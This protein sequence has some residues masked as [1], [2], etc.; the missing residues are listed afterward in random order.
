[1]K[2]KGVATLGEA[3]FSNAG[4]LQIF[5]AMKG[6]APIGEQVD[7]SSSSDT[8]DRKPEIKGLKNSNIIDQPLDEYSSAGSMIRK[9]RMYQE[10]MQLVPLPTQRGSVIPFTSWVGLAASIKELYGQPLHYLTNV[11]MKQWDQKRYGAD[12]EDI[13]LDTIIH[14]SKA[15]ASIWLTE[16][17]NRR[18]TSPYYIAKLWLADPMYHAHVDAIFPKLQSSPK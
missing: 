1:M 6:A 3:Q 7:I 16:E 14:P 10:Y 2:L 18:T 4:E 12:D 17:V 15:E 13:P 11:Q 8:D 9:A 5:T